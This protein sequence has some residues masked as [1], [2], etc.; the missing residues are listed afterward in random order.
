MDELAESYIAAQQVNPI[1]SKDEV[2]VVRDPL[3]FDLDDETFLDYA[4]KLKREADEFWKE[5]GPNGYALPTRRAKNEAF[6]FG[7]QNA[8]KKAKSYSSKAQD[9]LLWEAQAYRRA[10]ALSQLPD[11]TVKPG[12]D[13][14]ESK[15]VADDISK[16]VTSD[17]QSRN[18]KRVL[19]MAFDHHDVY[20][21]GVIKAFWNP[22]KGKF[23]D[24]D[25]KTIH[26]DLITLDFRS[27]T[28]DVRDMDFVFETCEKTVKEL[29][30]MFPEKKKDFFDELRKY[31]IFGAADSSTKPNENNQMGL[32]TK[33]K[34]Q[35][36]WFKWYDQPKDEDD[37]Q[38]WEEVIGVAWYFNGVLFRKIKHPY[39]DWSGTP[40]T[41]TYEMK[42]I[43][44]DKF[45]RSKQ[46]IDPQQMRQSLIDGSPI[47]GAETETIFRN[48]MDYPEFP[49][50]FIGKDQWGKTP[51]DETTWIEQDMMN[52]DTYDKRLGQIDKTIDRSKGKH[53]FSSSE[54][55]TKD[56]VS[57]MDLSDDDQD[58]LVDGDV[59]KV[60]AFIPGEQPSPALIQTSLDLRERIMDKGGVHGSTR[61][62]VDSETAATNN[63]IA[64]E[65][66]FTRMDD[67]VDDTINYAC[68]K[69]ANWEMQFIKL[70]YTE[71]HMRRILGPDGRFLSVKLHRDLVDDGMEVIISASGSDKLKAE[72]RAMDM[73]KMKLIDPFRFYTDVRASD[74]RGRTIALM[75][76]LMNPALYMQDVQNGGD[77]QGKAGL[78]ASVDKVNG[79]AADM[80][81]GDQ[82]QQTGSP[83]AIQDIQ[84]ITMGQVPQPP[85]Q[86][87]PQYAQTFNAFMQSPQVEQLIQQFGSAFQ[88][89]LT[90]FAQAIAQLQQAQ[91]QAP[92][93]TAPAQLGA[94]PTGGNQP[95]G[96]L[97]QNPS[98]DNTSRISALVNR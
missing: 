80:T 64:R 75:N 87:D 53:V 46:P 12:Q 26:P 59:T 61:G 42:E 34:Y 9:N 98:P 7:R 48:H 76:F 83:Q 31:S 72:Q 85:T 49:Y 69:M 52:Q 65:G 71:T 79:A 78:K 68:E 10:M 74:P 84:Q 45:E 32:N 63:Q 70:F 1:I 27:G 44:K 36:V 60:H 35:E 38:K 62:Q 17:I 13:T 81:Q 39:W 3:N 5:S 43:G 11:I 14:D 55:L 95:V 77:G 73:A 40:Q 25:F 56:D 8:N 58:I 94:P 88:Q 33:V 66:D 29:V 97:S 67:F 91:S 2:D 96:P 15:Q 93:N 18:R 22:Q 28:N 4:K 20:F 19:G 82:S 47:P 41:F 51:I 6:Y 23:G 90:T 92:E 57:N 54:G 89:Q 24:Y 37:K 50:I 16:I 86:I 30:M 21:T